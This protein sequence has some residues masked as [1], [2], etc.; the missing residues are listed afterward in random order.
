MGLANLFC[1]FVI[2]VSKKNVYITNIVGFCFW[3]VFGGIFSFLSLIYNNYSVCWY[4]LFGMILG[5]WLV[6]ISVDFFF[7]K[8]MQLLYNKF[9]LR[10]I[11]KRSNG[12][13][14]T[15]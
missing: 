10:K 1:R 12:E 2:R 9:A 8:L 7:T 13:L 11:R 14:Q 5:F 3:L 4:G 6:K 15:S